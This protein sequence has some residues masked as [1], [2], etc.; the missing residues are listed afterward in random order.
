MI[1]PVCAMRDEKVGFLSPFAESNLDTAK[2]NFAHACS[3]S[4][5]I[6]AFCPSDFVLYHIAD[7]DS[8]SGEVIPLSHH[9]RLID[10]AQLVG[11]FVDG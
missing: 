8:D 7:F 4:N 3:Q 10:G 6:Y 1:Y 11:G 5:S 2:R 9:E